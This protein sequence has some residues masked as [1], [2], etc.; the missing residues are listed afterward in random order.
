MA[1]GSHHKQEV[2][3][4]AGTRDCDP[5]HGLGGDLGGAPYAGASSRNLTSQQGLETS[6]ELGQA[7]DKDLI[8]NR[9]FSPEIK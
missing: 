2:I 8:R 3:G 1:Q 4:A 6:V 9:L 7:K 5:P